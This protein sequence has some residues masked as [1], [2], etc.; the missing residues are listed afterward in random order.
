M[1]NDPLYSLKFPVL[2]ESAAVD[3]LQSGLG[4]IAVLLYICSYPGFVQRVLLLLDEDCVVSGFG[5]LS[6]SAGSRPYELVL[7]F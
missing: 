2:A 3:V 7:T 6:V 1:L 5:I 4:G